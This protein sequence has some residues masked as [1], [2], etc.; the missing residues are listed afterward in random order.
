M[1]LSHGALHWPIPPC[2]AIPAH[3]EQ[4]LKS[5]APSSV[6][7]AW[8][9]PCLRQ[10]EQCS[11]Q[12]S[13]P[14]A[15]SGEARSVGVVPVNDFCSNSHQLARTTGWPMKSMTVPAQLGHMDTLHN[16][17][18]K[19]RNKEKPRAGRSSRG[20]EIKAPAQGRASPI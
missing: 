13:P 6:H 9:D 18:E 2:S 5:Q 10:K 12:P 7:P 15:C 20:H 3:T 19:K 16:N 4:V 14:P 8:A 11:A 1:E 17:I